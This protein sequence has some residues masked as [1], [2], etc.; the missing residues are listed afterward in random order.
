MEFIIEPNTGKKMSI[1]SK[2]GRNLLKKYIQ[3]YTNSL[4]KG[5]RTTIAR[6][7]LT[8]GDIGYL[9][10]EVGDRIT[11][12]D[13]KQRFEGAGFVNSY[14]LYVESRIGEISEIRDG[15]NF[16]D[17]Q[18]SDSDSI[19]T[20]IRKVS[21]FRAIDVTTPIILFVNGDSIHIDIPPA[22]IAIAEMV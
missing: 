12:N 4:N 22:P 2:N 13:A 5:G 19:E 17:Y 21:E 8:D 1:F 6:D 7:S 3:L 20:F 14:N 10:H 15:L 11:F 9:N 16:T 18:I